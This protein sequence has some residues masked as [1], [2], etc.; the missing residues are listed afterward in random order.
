MRISACPK[1]GAKP[2]PSDTVCLD[3]GQ[4]LLAAAHDI[5]EQAKAAARPTAGPA[6]P[7]AA[8]ANAAAAGLVLPGENAE[9]KRLRVF[10]KQEA[11]KLRAQ[12]PA[13]VVILLLVIG[14]TGAVLSLASKFLKEAG[15][16]AGVKTLDVPA[17]KEL[18]LNVFSDQRVMCV[19]TAGLALAGLLCLIGEA[20]RLWGTCMAIAAV[21]RNET[22]NVVHISSFTQIGLLVGAFFAPPIGLIL[23]VIFKLSKDDDT[24]SIG[25]L[26]IYASLLSGAILVVNWIWSLASASLPSR[27]QAL[28]GSGGGHGAS[29]LFRLLA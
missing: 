2:S 19:I 17:F 21:Q 14:G 27:P 8:V 13:M 24:N 18:G 15:G 23:G 20:R 6:S 26:M 22:P 12:R 10:D 11:D 1:C 9:E 3:C 29:A 28:P 16:W 4:D 5:V 7:A 25:S